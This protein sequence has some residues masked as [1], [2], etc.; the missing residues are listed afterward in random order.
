MGMDRDVG[1]D[2]VKRQHTAAVG[3]TRDDTIHVSGCVKSCAHRGPAAL[4]LVG[5]NGRYDLIRNGSTT[6]R[7]SLS[8]LGIDQVAALL[9]SVKG[10]HP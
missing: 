3:A 4:T 10:Q 5:R 1:G 7:P 6:D 9:Q 8:G 2:V